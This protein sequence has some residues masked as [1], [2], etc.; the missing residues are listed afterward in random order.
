ML[1]EELRPPKMARTLYLSRIKRK[2]RKKRKKKIRM[3]QTLLRGSC[4]KGK[5]CAPGE[6]QLADREISH[7]GG[8]TSKLWKKA[9]QPV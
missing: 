6:G 3:G 9:Q 5:K 4:E 1:A 2:K 7:D 8:G